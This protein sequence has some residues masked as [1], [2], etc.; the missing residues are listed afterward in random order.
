MPYCNLPYGPGVR[1]DTY[2][3]PGC[4]VSGFYDSLVSKLITWGSTFDESRRRM[5][6]ALDEF[7]IDGIKTTIPL[8]KTIMNDI[9]FINGELSTDYLDRYSIIDKMNDEIKGKFNSESK[10][11]PGVAAV[12]LF[13]E[14]AKNFSNLDNAK[15]VSMR[16]N[17]NNWKFGGVNN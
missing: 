16:N 4:T 11:L 10:V 1:V 2:L 14:Y 3:Y 17:S 15:E 5:I 8:Y 12:L 6:N 9:H 7:V 13:S